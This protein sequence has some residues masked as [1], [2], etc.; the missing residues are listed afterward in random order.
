MTIPTKATMLLLAF[1]VSSTVMAAD[2]GP[3]IEVKRG[4][5]DHIVLHAEQISQADAILVELFDT[6]N[7]KL[8]KAKHQDTARQL[9]EAAPHLL[10]ADIVTELRES[11]FTNISLAAPDGEQNKDH[12]LILSG[13]FTELNPGSQAVRAWIGFGAGESKV[14]VDASLREP[15][16]KTLAEISHC[17]KG[18]GWGASEAQMEADADRLGHQFALLMQNWAAGKYAN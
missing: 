11:G 4:P 15:A 8:G 7:A 10:A 14:C 5:L 16:G 2:A 3:N 12:S 18:I 17:S 1:L 13:Q 9:A 6:S